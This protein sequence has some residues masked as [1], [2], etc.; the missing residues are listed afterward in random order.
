ML[1][2]WIAAGAFLAGA[3]PAGIGMYRWE[4][5]KWNASRAAQKAEAAAELLKETNKARQ[6]EKDAGK[7]NLDTEIEH[8]KQKTA[9]A[10]ELAAARHAV[11]IGNV[12]RDPG[13]RES[14]CPAQGGTADAS[15]SGND[16]AG[17]QGLSQEATDFLFQF[18][19]DA[20]DNTDQLVI[21][22]AYTVKLLEICNRK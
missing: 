17:Q 5:N 12:L 4:E 6:K 18:A 15:A 21:V 20:D 19:S 2:V 8:G 10:L 22:Q 1:L 11:A 9:R 3:V 14:G 13:R 7:L 16:A